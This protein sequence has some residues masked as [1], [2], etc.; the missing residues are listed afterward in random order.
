MSLYLNHDASSTLTRIAISGDVEINPG[1]DTVCTSIG[2]LTSCQNSTRKP[3]WKFPCD[4]C[5]KLVRSNQKC[6]MCDGCGEWFHLKCI[7]MDLRTYIDLSSFDEQWFCD[8]I[9]CAS[10]FN[11]SDS[12]FQ[13]ANSAD[14]NSRTSIISSAG[15]NGISSAFSATRHKNA[16]PSNDCVKCL[17]L[18]VH[19]IRYKIMTYELFC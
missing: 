6:I 11:F 18:N 1:P 19:S 3:A 7:T 2:H 14:E 5:A 15:E 8:G 17:L 16:R 4:V 10:P 12:S 9:V 13:P